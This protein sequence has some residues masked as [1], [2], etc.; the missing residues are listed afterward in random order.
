MNKT[1]SVQESIDSCKEMKPLG[2]KV[3]SS[4]RLDFLVESLVERLSTRAKT[5][6]SRILIIIPSNRTKEFLLQAIV[7]KMGVYSER[8]LYHR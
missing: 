6:L 2:H 3:F 4:N 7:K 8:F 5:G 1:E